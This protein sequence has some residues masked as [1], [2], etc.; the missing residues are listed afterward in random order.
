RGLKL[1]FRVLSLEVSAE[2]EERILSIVNEDSDVKELLE[3]GYNITGIRPTIKAMVQANGDIT[4]KA[5]GA[6]VSMRGEG[7]WAQVQVDL[8]VGKVIR[9]VIVSKKVIEKSP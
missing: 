6:I 8:E 7:G 1:G 2:F 5:T 9:I 4:M 3:E